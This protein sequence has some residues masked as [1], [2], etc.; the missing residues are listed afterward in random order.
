MAPESQPTAYTDHGE[1][2]RLHFVVQPVAADLQPRG[3]L[4]DS[5]QSLLAVTGAIDN[6]ILVV[7]EPTD[8]MAWKAAL[9]RAVSS[10]LAEFVIV[11]CCVVVIG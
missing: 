1:S 11:H 3:Y 9:R 4:S 5:E 8:A 10:E 6:P 7:H 2:P